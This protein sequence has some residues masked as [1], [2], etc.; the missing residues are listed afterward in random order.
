[1]ICYRPKC[2]KSGFLKK[3]KSHAM[4]ALLLVFLL[5][6]PDTLLMMKEL[7]S[8]SHC[9]MD[10]TDA[11]LFFLHNCPVWVGKLKDCSA[12]F[13]FSSR[14]LS[15]NVSGVFDLY[16]QP[17]TMDAVRKREEGREEDRDRE[18]ENRDGI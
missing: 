17:D 3:L 9:T 10:L 18:T 13:R 12:L 11:F 7:G 14:Y 1:M 4:L 2:H 15:S 5:I 16:L 8:G 6:I